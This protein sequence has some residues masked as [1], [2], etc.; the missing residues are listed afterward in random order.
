[1]NEMD[2]LLEE[3]KKIMTAQVFDETGLDYTILERHKHLLSQ[4]SL[5]SNSGVAV[6]DMYRQQHVFVSY[7][8][9][10]LFGYDMN[11]L[12]KNGNDYFN[13]HVHPDD[14][15]VLMRNGV[16]FLRLF[17]IQKEEFSNCKLINEYRIRNC[18]NDY[19]RIIEQHQILEFDKIG[20]AW[21]SLS[22]W[23]ISPDQSTFQGVRSKLFNCK[24]GIYHSLQELLP[25]SHQTSLSPREIEVLQLVRDGLLSKEISEK[26]SI[27]VHTVNTHRQKILM[28]L[29][30]DNSMEAIKYAS[31][32]GL[33]T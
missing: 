14:I 2:K 4:L 31:E 25:T 21:L 28:K 16:D 30:V 19:V 6:F 15:P 1:M 23:D 3:Y 20:N 18:H 29:N 10:D 9:T 26:L 13:D 27:S 22:I 8:F 17:Y 32:L 7:N 12:E 24:T 11:S 5:I 33:L